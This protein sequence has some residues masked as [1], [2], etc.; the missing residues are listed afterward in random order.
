ML[1]AALWMALT[2]NLSFGR[3]VLMS[4]PG[5]LDV[6]EVLFLASLPV[7]VTALLVLVLAP[8][9]VSR[10]LKPVLVVTLVVAGVCGYFMDTFRVVIS[11]SM[12]A[13]AMQTDRHEAGELL[14]PIFFVH[15]FLRGIVPAII[16][17]RVRIVPRAFFPDLLRQL[18]LMAAALVVVLVVVGAQYK[19]FSLWGRAHRD[20][21]MYVNPTYPYYSLV[22]YFEGR[23]PSTPKG[24]P[25]PIASDA[26]RPQPPARPLFVVLVVGETARA[27]NFQLDGYERPTNPALA[28]LA[29]VV[30][31]TDVHSCGTATAESVPCMFSDLGRRN[32]SVA[33]A[34]GQ[35]NLLDVLKRTG[36]RVVWRDNNSGCKG[37]CARVEYESVEDGAYHDLCTNGE[38]LDETLTRDLDA[39]APTPDKPATLLVLHQ[40]GSHGPAYYLR[41]P[42][43]YRRFT[44]DCRI[45][46]VQQCPQE[47]IVNAYDNTI[48]YTDFVLGRLIE[49]LRAR[50]DRMDTLLVYMSDHGE[51][52]GENGV[53]L[54][55]LPY[56]IA[57]EGQTHIP[58]VIWTSATARETLGID[59]ACLG[60]A[61]DDALSHDNLFHS[62]LGVFG[63]ETADYDAKLDLFAACRGEV[64]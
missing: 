29:D 28:V 45:D 53:Y 62:V 48:A 10:L 64:P 47:Q 13:N 3:A 5:A 25:K 27:A 18:G 37:V 22:K 19:T 52:L 16:V 63:V 40:K 31:F 51:S 21:R 20:V 7:V 38:C 50:Q 41:Y 39:Y 4:M 59:G 58:M 32:F 24:P 55:G 12:I 1:A 6:P 56:S 26:K 14:R 42:D 35:E 34:A 49:E 54:H 46:D 33:K 23:A 60:R 2:Q 61:S 30:S 9:T 36:V 57:P 8:L 17:A 15:I 44:P 43:T 11:D